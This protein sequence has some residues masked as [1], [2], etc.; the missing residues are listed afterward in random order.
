MSLLTVLVLAIIPLV[1]FAV[2]CF[3]IS[4]QHYDYD[5][6][7]GDSTYTN[8][9]YPGWLMMCP[10][11]SYG[12]A[13]A[14][15]FYCAG[16]EGAD[17]SLSGCGDGTL[18]SSL[19][20]LWL[21]TAILAGVSIYLHAILPSPHG[22]PDH[23][24]LC[25]KDGLTG[26]GD[27]LRPADEQQEETD[28]EVQSEDTDV[29]RE[30]EQSRRLIDEGWGP[31]TLLLTHDVKKQ[32]GRL[33]PFVVNGVSVNMNVNECFC[34]LGP[35]GAG[36]TTFFSLLTTMISHDGRGDAFVAG[37]DVHRHPALVR[38]KIGGE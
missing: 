23:P 24:L 29:V 1:S 16:K 27:D 31:E 26:G 28:V 9:E 38:E 21:S 18:L 14:L 11:F 15:S 20:Y 35:N 7:T 2:M 6:R 37:V 17:N 19:G 5:P 4:M 12:R 33:N 34:L 8:G 36:K 13:A 3:T 32:Y 25:L 22:V 10:P 30:R